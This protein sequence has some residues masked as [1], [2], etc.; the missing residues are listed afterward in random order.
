MKGSGVVISPSAGGTP[1]PL[2]QVNLLRVFYLLIALIMGSEQWSHLLGDVDDWTTW[3]SIGKSMLAALALL[4]LLGALRPL[5]MLPLLLFEM[6]WKT[7]W[8]VMIAGRAW[9]KGAV[10]PEIEG[11]FYECIGIVVLFLVMPWRY[12]WREYVVQPA[13]RWRRERI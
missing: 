10:T 7:V 8:L 2:W 6:T 12:V 1:V 9:M 3:K 4:C 11:T 13:E 5:K